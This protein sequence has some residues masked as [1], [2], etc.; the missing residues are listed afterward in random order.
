[1]AYES[2]YLRKPY[3][4]TAKQAVKKRENCQKTKRRKIKSQPM[5]QR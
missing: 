5:Q 4:K 2:Q 1:M 3:K